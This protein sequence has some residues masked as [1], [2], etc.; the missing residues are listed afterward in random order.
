MLAE[1]AGV[2]SAIPVA[3]PNFVAVGGGAL[4]VW[5]HSPPPSGRR[6]GAI[7]LCPPIGYEYM[8]AYR[9]VRILAERLAALGFDALR[10]DY[11][12]TG[13]STGDN[14]Q[15]GR[16]GCVDAW[17]RSVVCAIAEARRLAG[18]DAVAVV[19]IRAGALVAL[20]AIPD[21]GVV[22]RLVLWSAFPSGQ[23]YLRELKAYAGLNR[24]PHARE[25]G[26]EAGDEA[27][28]GINAAGYIVTEQTVTSIARW[29]MD[30]VATAPAEQILLVDRDD[31]P[32]NLKLAAHLQKVGASVTRIQP[33]GTAEMLDLP[34]YAKVP[35]TALEEILTWFGPWLAAS[36]RPAVR[37]VS[38]D[39]TL[40]ADDYR[41][42]LVRFGRGDRL[43]GVLTSPREQMKKAPS[44]VLFNT[45]FEYHVGP[46][47]LYVP[48]ARYW[49]ARGH[50]VLRYDL[51]GIGDSAPPPGS[52]DNVAYP[53]HMLDDAREAIAFVK[54]VAM[55]GPVIAAGLCSGGWLAF[56][57]ARDGLAV[58]AVVSINPP[59]YL[60]DRNAGVQWVA[61]ANEFDR[62]Q[63]SMRDPS[64]WLKALSG[65]AAYAHFMRV[66][67]SALRRSVAARVGGLL[68]DALPEGLA[69]DL[70]TI[71]SRGVK[72]L[73]VFSRGDDGLQYFQWHAQPALRRARVRDFVQ[74]LVVEGAGHTFRPRAAQQT[75]RAILIDFVE[76]Q[77][78]RTD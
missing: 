11:E 4:F 30:A 75:L 50:H 76:S 10:I 48:L 12:G 66:S 13:N 2:E 9:T 36:S 1:R 47:R 14:A 64:K 55:H 70:G 33:Q 51:G 49:A 35:E 45:G 31:R 39:V 27:E 60:R 38:R 41:E 63:H 58:D 21:I 59:M 52:P 40:E 7:V 26:D 42:R 6:G 3:Q 53:A 54:K 43:F 56:Q 71:A 20:H 72:S 67:A 18:S 15:P 16:P 28:A 44:I 23:A 69:N 34:H 46:H 57:A 5:H 68:G 25:D 73:F 17:R 65:G 74:Q 32:P 61:N 78:D 19:G 62:Y 77:T 37:T 8:S 29:T 24:E 22:D